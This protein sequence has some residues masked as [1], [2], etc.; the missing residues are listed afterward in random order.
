VT[1]AAIFLAIVLINLFGVCGALGL[2]LHERLERPADLR[3]A[4]LII[5]LTFIGVGLRG[6]WFEWIAWAPALLALFLVVR[7]ARAINTRARARR[8]LGRSV[9]RI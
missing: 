9:P 8:L 2:A 3:L 1:T 7:F 4:G 5:V 6:Q